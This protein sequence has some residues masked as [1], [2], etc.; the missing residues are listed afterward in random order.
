MDRTNPALGRSLD[1]LHPAVLRLIALAAAGAASHGRWLGVCGGLAA[2][3]AAVP[4]LLGLG[5]TELSVPPA[6]VPATKQAVRAVD[7][8]AAR[9]LAARAV[10]LPTA[11]AV[12]ALVEELA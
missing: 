9:A 1:A 5:V 7:L 8:P 6:A 2:D 10:A 12:R 3:A 4:L 11:A